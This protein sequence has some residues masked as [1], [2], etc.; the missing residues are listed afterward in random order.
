MFKGSFFCLERAS[1]HLVQKHFNTHQQQLTN[2]CLC[3]KFGHL[4]FKI[5]V[6]SLHR[7]FNSQ[8]SSVTGTE[9]TK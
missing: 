4:T 7:N 1:L 8:F 6:S 2:L 3:E 5:V 9:E